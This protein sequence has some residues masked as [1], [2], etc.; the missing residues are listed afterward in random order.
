MQLVAKTFYGLE[1]I[2]AKELEELE[3]DKIKVL[4]R[5]VAFEANKALLYRATLSLRTALR[6]LRPVFRCRAQSE[7]ALYALVTAEDWTEYLDPKKTFA[8]QSVVRSEYFK[9]SK[10][11]A[12]KTKD[13]IVDQIRR[14]IGYRPNINP[15]HPDI[16]LHLHIYRDQVEISLDS[17]GFSLHRRGY[18][19]QGHRAPINEALAAG[20][21]RIAGWTPDKTLLDPMCGTG[22]ILAEA[23]MIAARI[24]AR[25][26]QESFCFQ[27]WK[28]YSD[29]LWKSILEKEKSR[30]TK[31]GWS[32]FGYEIDQSNA[33]L[34][35]RSLESI[36]PQPAVE[37]VCT[38]F[39]ESY[40]AADRGV[41]IMN[42][43][44][45]ERLNPKSVSDFYAQIGDTLKKKYAGWDAWII[46]S[47]ID[48]LK[49]IGLRR[50]QKYKLY[51]G[52]LECAYQ[53][54]SLYQGTKKRRNWV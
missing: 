16:N 46:S 19:N 53:K 45:G 39:F 9:H 34:A 10:Y 6:I 32:L 5:A 25:I 43:P 35:K 37:L 2:L 41:I 14:H 28:D 51:N 40:P 4:H 24:P 50:T 52:A 17:S 21:I 38:D 7:D 11:I 15:K 36:L 33:D 30:I 47:N 3:A 18:R 44:Y 23:L 1:N 29:D 20:L 22:T 12:L 26:F 13:A 42:P 31:G 48:A 49:S 54:Y 27:N 8:I